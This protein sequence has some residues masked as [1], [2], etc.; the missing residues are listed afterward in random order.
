M[1][2]D[3]KRERLMIY[4]AINASSELAAKKGTHPLEKGCNCIS[5]IN[6]RKQLLN[7]TLR[8]WKFRL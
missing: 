8:N 6:K 7:K 1:K 3:I 4:E 2:K 5:C